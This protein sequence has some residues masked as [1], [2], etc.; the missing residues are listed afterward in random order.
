MSQDFF[1]WLDFPKPGT[2]ANNRL[3]VRGWALTRTFHH[4]NIKLFINGLPVL[5]P[6]ERILRPDVL[7]AHPVL[8]AL[9]PKP[10]FEQFLDVSDF[11]DGT[12]TFSCALSGQGQRV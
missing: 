8:A 11:A 4:P 6:I 9:N 10:G 2:V 3:H 1:G 7:S 12:Y 5:A